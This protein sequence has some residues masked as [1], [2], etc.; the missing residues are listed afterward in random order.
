[1]IIHDFNELG[2]AI[3]PLETDAPLII[4]PDAV[5]TATIALQ[6]FQPIARRNP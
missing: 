6:R 4:D 2:T 5:L 3:V 1:M